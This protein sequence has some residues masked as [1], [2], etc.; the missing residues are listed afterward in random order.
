MRME[1]DVD[2]RL[3]RAFVLVAERG[4]FSAA[5]AAL[6]ITQP[7]LSRRIVELE[8]ALGL[9]LFER[10]SRRVALTQSGED[11][12]ARC[13]DLLT[14][15]E[16][17]RERARA[18]A[19]GKAGILRVGCAPMTMESVVAPALGAYRK[20]C[21]DVEVQL[22]E[23]G[24]EHAQQAVLRGQLHA[25]VASP[26]EP[27]LETRR[28]FPWRLLAVVP[29]GHP[30][31]RGRTVEIQKLAKESVL[32][33]PAGFGTRALFDAGC[34]TIGLRPAIGMEVAASQSLVAAARAGHGVAVVPSVLT[35]NKRAVK[36]LP[37]L[38][39]GKSLGRWMVVAWNP[40]PAPPAY[41]VEFAGVLAQSLEGDYPGREY[42]F[43]PAIEPPR[44]LDRKTGS[45]IRR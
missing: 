7:A 19:Q 12:L 22:R 6:H 2:L 41:L 25:A 21:P 43:A 44:S 17:L 3:L 18:L 33:L 16:A 39:R 40:E 20:R 27:R 38:V 24:G 8:S 29:Q 36:A 1:H 45:A 31:A 32:T 34:E 9:R 28:L 4:G 23:Q 30:L 10:T 42:D 15:G 5:A 13:R 26:T 14:G 35:F 37:L 11:L